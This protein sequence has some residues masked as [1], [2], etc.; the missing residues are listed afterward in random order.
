MPSQQ[1]VTDWLTDMSV[2][3]MDLRLDNMA[4]AEAALALIE[5]A[6]APPLS[7]DQL[8]PHFTLSE[9]VASSTAQ[10]QGIDNT[11]D[12]AAIDQLSALANDTL[13][14]IRAIC[15]DNP[16]IVSSGYRSPA[17]NAAVGGATNSAHLFGCAAD[18]TIPGFGSV[19]DVC[20][21]LMPRLAELEIDQLIDESGGGA[22]WVHVGRAIP[23]STTPRGQAFTISNGQTINGIA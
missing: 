8:S 18:F 11:P 10:A 1:D 13:E 2:G 22:R 19:S 21:A 12:E 15:G 5:P 23:P 3:K 20:H 7:D 14:G 17:L 4:L 6:P 9:L 16:V